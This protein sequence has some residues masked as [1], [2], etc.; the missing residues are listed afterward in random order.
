MNRILSCVAAV[1]IATSVGVAGRQQ[2]ASAPAPARPAATP[3]AAFVKQYCIGCHN[4]RA[5]A[6]GLALDTLNPLNVAGHAEAWEKVVRKLRTGAMPPDGAPKPAPAA[7]QTFT[8]A[9]ETALDAAAARRLDPGA[10]ALHRLN[11]TEYSNAIRDLLALDVDVTA[12]LPP[13]DSTAGFDNI[14]D[15]LGVSPA[16]IEGYVAAAAKISRLAVGDP[17]IG[18]DRVVYRV[19]GDLSQDTQLEGLPIGTRGGIVVRHTFPLDAEYDIQVGQAGGGARLGGAPPAAGGR[20]DG[21]YV[22]IDG[23]RIPVQ[24]RGGTRI[25][26][27]A[28]PHTIAA[29]AL[30]GNPAAG[31]DGIF[32]IAARA[33]GISQIAIA[34]PHNA[35]GPGDTPSRRRLFVCT[36]ASAADEEPCARRILSTLLT[37]AYRRPVSASAPELLTPLEFYRAGRRSGTFDSGVQR[38]LARV[39]VDPFFLFRFER[40]PASIA[41]GAAYR[42]SDLELASRLSFF[43]WS[44]I[45]DDELIAVAAKGAL[46]DPATLE[47]QVRRML[48]DP[49]AD[50][51]VANFAGQWLFLRELKNARPD[52]PGFDANLR[53][54][55]Q[56]ETELLFRTI[57]QEDRSVVEFLDSDFTFVDERLARHYGFDGIRGP[58]MRRVTIP[59]DSPRRG[60]LGHGSVLTLTSAANRTSPVVRGK[61]ILDNLM[62]TPPPQPPPGVETNLEKDP[63]QVKVTSLRQRLEQHRNSPTCAACH[64]L[65]DPI[66]LALENFDHTGRWREMDGGARIDAT[67]QLADGTKVTGPDSLRRALLARSDVFVSVVAEKLLTYAVGRPMRPEDMP[68][69]R[70]IVR[71]AAPQQYRLSSL[72]LQAVRTPQFQMRTKAVK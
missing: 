64:R 13:D 22:A 65:I 45:P 27:L 33:P 16:L 4:S 29:A 53:A 40:E 38:A 58:R 6:G 20:G 55:M 62:G 50:A 72:I 14:A 70:A 9:L 35:T 8:T 7:R 31:A 21:P 18:L 63:Q 47:R 46:K 67:G 1:F 34:G 69:V 10:P 24:G 5:N 68:A 26:V 30:A 43:L 66:G 19:P 36:P 42:I 2:A 54:S 48:S 28:G 15:V 23:V 51:L 3:D 11:R 59:A 37:R 32:D 52:A 56:R 41:A 44:S 71:G 25:R 17:S 61:W 49:R 57:L 39:L 60:L 12:L